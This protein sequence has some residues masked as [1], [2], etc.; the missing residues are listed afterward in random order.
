MP[1]S[2]IWSYDIGIAFPRFSCKTVGILEKAEF[3]YIIFA[4]CAVPVG[5]EAVPGVLECLVVGTKV[6]ALILTKQAKAV[7]EHFGAVFYV[8]LPEKLFRF[9]IR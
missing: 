6:Q 7:H 9:F 2:G 1:C 3:Q 8:F 5:S 4:G